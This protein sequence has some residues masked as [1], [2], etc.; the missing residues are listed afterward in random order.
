MIGP[1]GV[2]KDSLLN[3]LKKHRLHSQQP[4]V[5]H[6]YITRPVRLNDENHV[7][8]SDAE[9]QLRQQAGLF[10]F[11]W[12]SHGNHYGIG[13]EVLHWLEQGQNVI[14]NGSRQYLPEAQRLFPPL[15]PVWMTVSSEVLRHRL[16]Q[17][18]RESEA[19]IESRLA[20]N[21][22][23][24]MPES[25]VRLRNDQSLESVAKDLMAAL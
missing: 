10:L 11:H 4:L 20:R 7:Q 5:A 8:L 24:E 16:L 6:R 9:F 2:G 18:G 19:E 3:H 15:V 25:G 12:H 21:K 13:R 1:S 14:V 17:R 22:A 23:L